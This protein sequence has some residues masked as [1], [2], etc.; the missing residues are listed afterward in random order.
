MDAPDNST[1]MKTIRI[2]IN[3]AVD[4]NNTVV[5][6]ANAGISVRIE[7]TKPNTWTTLYWVV[8]ELP[9]NNIT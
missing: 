3:N 2:N 7:E 6:L 9:E 5:A 8:F 4:R 1:A